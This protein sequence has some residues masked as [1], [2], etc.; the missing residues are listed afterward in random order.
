MYLS[1]TGPETGITAI[2]LQS[3]CILLSVLF[4]SIHQQLSLFDATHALRLVASPL[5]AEVVF[6]SIEGLFRF[7]PSRTKWIKIHPRTIYIFGA[8]LLPFWFGLCLS[9]RF[10]SQAFIDGELCSNATF[11]D[12][13]SELRILMIPSDSDPFFLQFMLT[14]YLGR[15]YS[16][17][18]ARGCQEWMA[19]LRG[20]KEVAGPRG[21]LCVQFV[22]RVWYISIVLGA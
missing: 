20:Y 9:L 8:L 17:Y 5:V 6:I 16:G 21:R 15:S 14:F 12:L 22:E 1:P 19:I 4:S 11:K 2:I 3:Y 7:Q 10:S 13:L 18:T